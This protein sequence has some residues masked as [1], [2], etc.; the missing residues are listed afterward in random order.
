MPF[1]FLIWEKKK[2]HRHSN[3]HVLLKMFQILNHVGKYLNTILCKNAGYNGKCWMNSIFKI[4]I[5]LYKTAQ[6]HILYIKQKIQKSIGFNWELK[7][8]SKDTLLKLFYFVVFFLIILNSHLTFT[9][10][11]K[12]FFF[13][14][15]KHKGKLNHWQISKRKSGGPEDL[16]FAANHILS[17]WKFQ[18]SSHLTGKNFQ[19]EK[20]KSSLDKEKGISGNKGKW[21]TTLLEPCTCSTAILHST[22]EASVQAKQSWGRRKESGNIRFFWD[23]RSTNL[24]PP[25]N[26]SQARLGRPIPRQEQG[27]CSS[28]QKCVP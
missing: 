11:K 8:S 13:F 17:K 6:D 14:L 24:P 23:P 28:R 15:K 12:Q 26:V 9:S 27:H 16:G 3:K 1:L 10:R 21:Q 19:A 25:L 20:S 18:G 4:H 7:F 5:L 2:S 22:L